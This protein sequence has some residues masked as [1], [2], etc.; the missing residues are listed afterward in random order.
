MYQDTTLREVSLQKES[1]ATYALFLNKQTHKSPELKR[2]TPRGNLEGKEHIFILL[3]PCLCCFQKRSLQ[4]WKSPSWTASLQ[5]VLE[6]FPDHDLPL[7]ILLKFILQWASNQ[8]HRTLWPLPA[9]SKGHS[10]VASEM[11]RTD[12]QAHGH[13]DLRGCLCHQ[14]SSCPINASWMQALP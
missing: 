3:V 4:L 13:M 2:F 8:D 9:S 6:S 11:A 14:G 1:S 7:H 12:R 5:S 10:N